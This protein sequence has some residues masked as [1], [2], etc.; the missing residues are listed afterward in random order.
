MSDV[1]PFNW[2]VRRELWENRFLYLAPLVV[3]AFVLL[4]T[5]ISV[6]AL[7]HRLR[8]MRAMDAVQ[9]HKTV[10]TPFS[11]APAPILFTTFLVGMFYSLDALYGERRDRSILFWKSLPVS[12]R[13]TVLSKAAIPLVMLPLIGM[14]I[15][16]VV[17]FILLMLSAP[18]FAGHG[19]SPATA[20][21]EFRFFQEPIVMVYGLTVH[22]LWMAPIYAWLL[23]VSAWAKR[24]PVLWATL[25]L[26]AIG[27]LERL[28]LG[29]TH[30]AALVKYRFMGAMHEAFVPQNAVMIDRLADLDPVRFLTAPGLW[31]GLI[32]AAAFLAAAVRLRRNHEPI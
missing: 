3:S 31:T 27:I 2:S 10:V 25:P 5:F 6:V 32:A 9:W 23:F 30:F 8:T 17:Q 29:T 13:T 14:A 21:G 16:L 24:M 4:G 22:S 12:D 28:A 11:M 20:L 18:I 15:G 7:A 26:V 19:M 1:R